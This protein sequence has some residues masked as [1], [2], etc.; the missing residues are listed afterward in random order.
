MKS[1]GEGY[2]LPPGIDPFDPVGRLSFEEICS[3]WGS[4]SAYFYRMSHTQEEMGEHARKISAGRL[5]NITPERRSEIA[6]K[7]ALARWGARKAGS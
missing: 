6:R 7:A 1:T 3:I 4:V 2:K 5:A